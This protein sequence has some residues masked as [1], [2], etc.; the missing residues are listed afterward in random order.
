[1]QLVASQLHRHFEA[2]VRTY[3]L[4]DLLERWF[5][6]FCEDDCCRVTHPTPSQI[7]TYD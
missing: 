3:I 6:D 5:Y 2:A 7:N 1:M 4:E